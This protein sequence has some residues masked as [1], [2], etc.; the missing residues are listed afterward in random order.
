MISIFEISDSRFGIDFEFGIWNRRSEIGINFHD[1]ACPATVFWAVPVF[2]AQQ[3]I[4]EKVVVTANA[5][6]GA[7]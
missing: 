2:A 4:E 5:Y 3:P 1:F 7:L 6:P